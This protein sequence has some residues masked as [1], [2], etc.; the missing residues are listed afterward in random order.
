MNWYYTK[1][2]HLLRHGQSKEVSA[3]WKIEK[4]NMAAVLRNEVIIIRLRGSV[5]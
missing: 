1:Y 5:S 3:K 4:G 2:G